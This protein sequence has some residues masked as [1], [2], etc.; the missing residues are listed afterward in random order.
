M[1]HRTIEFSDGQLH[2]MLRD[3]ILASNGQFILIEDMQRWD[4]WVEEAISPGDKQYRI[5]AIIQSGCQRAID[6]IQQFLPTMPQ[7]AIP[8]ATTASTPRHTSEFSDNQLYEIL[9]DKILISNNQLVCLIN[10]KC[11]GEWV[12]QDPS[13]Q[14]DKINAIVK[15]GF[16]P[17]IQE[18]QHL[19]PH[20]AIPS[21]SSVTTTPKLRKRKP[22]H[23]T[24][25]TFAYKKSGGPHLFKPASAGSSASVDQQLQ[26]LVSDYIKRTRTYK[27]PI[28]D[29]RYI[30]LTISRNCIQPHASKEVVSA[31]RKKIETYS[32]WAQWAAKYD[33]RPYK[34]LLSRNRHAI[35]QLS[36]QQWARFIRSNRH[37]ISTNNRKPP[38]EHMKKN[39]G[40][41]HQANL[42]LSMLNEIKDLDPSLASLIGQVNQ[43]RKAR[44]DDVQHQAPSL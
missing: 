43:E 41:F 21:T 14:H 12:E 25:T 17:A 24:P 13:T 2:D 16:Q 32:D 9:R 30:L 22:T 10:I 6:E 42:P 29:E 44:H 34:I 33:A 11:W 38:A 31:A 8:T 28:V 5:D 3:K 26:K 4:W 18:I 35:Y 1:P 7:A 15:S 36:T 40:Y 23:T 19:L 37:P 39:I 27:A 20:V